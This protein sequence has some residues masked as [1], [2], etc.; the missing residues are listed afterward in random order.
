MVTDYFS[1]YS[2]VGQLQSTSSKTV[3]SSL[4]TVLARHAIPYELFTD[5]GPQF[6]SCEFA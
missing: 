1:N 4:K 5:S 3:I 6:S 2:E